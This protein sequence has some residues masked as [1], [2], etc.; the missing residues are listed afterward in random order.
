MTYHVS[1]KIQTEFSA[2]TIQAEVPI[3]RNNP[4][5]APR[6]VKGQIRSKVPGRLVVMFTW[7]QHF[8]EIHLEFDWIK[9]N[10]HPINYVHAIED[11]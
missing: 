8:G 10:N 9:F 1:I 6:D 4:N 5:D 2:I 3:Q 7:F 11:N